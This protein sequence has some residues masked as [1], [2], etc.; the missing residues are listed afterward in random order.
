MRCAYNDIN[1]LKTGFL[2]SRILFAN[3]PGNYLLTNGEKY[4][5][6]LKDDQNDRHPSFLTTR[7]PSVKLYIIPWRRKTK[8]RLMWYVFRGILKLAC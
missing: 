5:A 3:L 6:A 7:L 1:I 8:K 2:P 4:L